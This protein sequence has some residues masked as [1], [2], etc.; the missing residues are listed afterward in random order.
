MIKNFLKNN[1]AITIVYFAFVSYLLT[2]FR[3]D[4]PYQ[5]ISEIIHKCSYIFLSILIVQIIIWIRKKEI[6]T[7]NKVIILAALF[8]INTYF[9]FNYYLRVGEKVGIFLNLLAV[10]SGMVLLL[11]VMICVIVFLKNLILSRVINKKEKSGQIDYM[12]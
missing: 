5:N 11:Q 3:S 9:L 12:T 7:T 4:N 2:G 8:V 10:I 1:W 6:L